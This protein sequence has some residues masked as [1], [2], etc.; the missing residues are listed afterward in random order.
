[1]PI[2]IK[3]YFSKSSLLTIIVIT[4][5]CGGLFFSSVYGKSNDPDRAITWGVGGTLFLFIYLVISEII[6]KKQHKSKLS[7]RSFRKIKE[8]FNFKV[9]NIND[10]WGFKGVYKNYF[11]RL[12]FDNLYRGGRI[13]ILIYYQQPKNNY[14][15]VDIRLLDKINHK[16]EVNGMF[17]SY[18][19][20]YDTSHI[21]I[22]TNG[23]YNRRP[24]KVIKLIEEGISTLHST[25]LKPISEIEVDELITNDKYIHT[26]LTETYEIK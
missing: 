12:F 4:V 3:K 1:M 21:R 13:G 24:T 25:N 11:I 17:E 18:S 16:Y 14:G 23:W 7:T 6:D 19:R 15:G 8:H 9:E 2:E 5:I 22:F 26:P 20:I 10:Y